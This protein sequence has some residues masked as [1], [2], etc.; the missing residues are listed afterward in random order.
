MTLLRKHL[1]QL[2][3]IIKNINMFEEIREQKHS[4]FN[5]TGYLNKFLMI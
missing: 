2:L 4:L 1:L 5:H 3:I